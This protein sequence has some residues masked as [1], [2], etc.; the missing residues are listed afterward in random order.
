MSISTEIQRLQTAKADIKSAIEEKGVTVGDGT[1]DT[2]AEKIS[3]ISGSADDS[4][5][6][7]F[8]DTF[9]DNGNRTEYGNAF[10]YHWN[11][12]TFKPKYDIKP[13]K[14]NVMFYLANI[15]KGLPEIAQ[16]QGI[17]FDFSNCNNIRQCFA[18]SRITDTGIVDIS[19]TGSANNL[20]L[21]G[22]QVKTAHIITLYDG[23]QDLSGTFLYA[24]KLEDLTIDG[25]IGKN[26]TFAQSRL[27]SNES[28]QNIIDHLA[29]LTGVATQTVTFYA[30]VGAK[31]TD[32]QKAQI[33]A[34]NWELVY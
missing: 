10:S 18:Y 5:Y 23:T 9:Q 17:V 15:E 11:G 20:L 19:K 27:L 21:Q 3:E 1:I 16:E 4:Y 28:V 32:E 30:T 34:K 31:L 2:Y 25:V 8:W 29:D 14:A 7:T 12:E 33:T 13:K 22:S 26:I 24:D 6:D